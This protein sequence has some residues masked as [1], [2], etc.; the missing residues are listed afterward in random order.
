MLLK[1]ENDL[2]RQSPLSAAIYHSVEMLQD[3]QASSSMITSWKREDY[4]RC[5]CESVVSCLSLRDVVHSLQSLKKQPES[6][7]MGA[8]TAATASGDMELISILIDRGASIT[9]QSKFFCTPMDTAA[10]YGCL[11]ALKLL[12]QHSPPNRS[13]LFEACYTGRENIVDM[14]DLYFANQYT[15]LELEK[16][17]CR[18]IAGGHISMVQRL[19]ERYDAADR[20]VARQ[21]AFF[22]AV[23]NNHIG[24]VIMFLD[25]GAQINK[26]DFRG[27][28]AMEMASE[29]GNL[30][31]AELLL[32]RGFDRSHRFYSNCL[33]LAAQQGHE[34]MVQL[35]LNNGVDINAS[36]GKVARR[37]GNGG[38]RC[39]TALFS[40]AIRGEF[41][42]FQFLLD[43][44]ADVYG[45]D[46]GAALAVACYTQNE[47][48]KSLLVNAG[49]DHTHCRFLERETSHKCFWIKD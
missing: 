19:I 13:C 16:M 6:P 18:S 8:L 39:R 36:R 45:R 4:I 7:F 29:N 49:V 23:Q 20:P 1:I 41:H 22:H 14:L 46:G 24:L 28:T 48:L 5:L 2:L 32:A 35:L 11:D 9:A 27:E 12:L 47:S 30:R 42:M 26:T 34:D 37:G 44:G 3:L 25:S 40:A 10:R 38:D 15:T 33:I 21:E 31:M 43:R 17:I